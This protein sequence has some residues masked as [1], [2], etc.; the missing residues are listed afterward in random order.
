MFDWLETVSHITLRSP[1]GAYTAKILPQRGAN[2]IS[3]THK[4]SGADVLRTCAKYS[5]FVDD[6]PY[7]YGMPI[8]FFPN[9]I[10]GGRFTFEGR[11]YTL[12]INE[13]STGCA[14]HGVIHETPFALTEQSENSA[15]FLYRATEKQ[16]YLTFPHAFT[17]TVHYELG[18]DGLTQRVSVKNDSALDMPMGLAYHTT[19]RLPFLKNGKL[20]NVRLTLPVGTEYERDMRDYSMTWNTIDDPA[21]RDAIGKGKIC[22]AENVISRHFARPAGAKMKLTDLASGYSIVYRAD[23]QYRFWMVWNGGNKDFMCVEPQTWMN[24][25]LNA[26]EK[27]GDAGVITV[28][29]SETKVFTTHLSVEKA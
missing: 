13:P 25:A 2:C 7:L 23:D 8:L 14:I 3:L 18:N 27:M 24:N 11:E 15:T 9:R 16:P 20:E 22:P 1:D 29:P 21:F 5:D 6:N 19:F 17:F 4:P 28:K 10:T 12:P 26:P